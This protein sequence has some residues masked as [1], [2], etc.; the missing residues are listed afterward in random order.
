[1]NSKDTI[2]IF[3]MILLCMTAIGLKN[4]VIVIP[5]LLKEAGRDAWISVIAMSLLSL[6]WCILIIYIY[7]TMKGKQIQVW[8]QDSI[9]KIVTNILMVIV[10]IYLVIMAAVT[11][12]ETIM[13]TNVSYLLSTP[14]VVLTII[15]IVPVL[16]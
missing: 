5:P 3:Q 9:G 14:P 16:L 2:S 7:K 6:V 1:M 11:L 13:W 8:L 4:H 15:F 10:S 12:K